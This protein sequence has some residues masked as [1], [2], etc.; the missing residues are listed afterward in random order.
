MD[1]TTTAVDRITPELVMELLRP[2]EVAL[3]ADG[4]RVAFGV[5][6]SFRERGKLIETR[7]WTG[8]V[9]GELRP[10]EAGTLPRFSPD[11]SRLA[12]ASDRGTRGAG[13]SGSTTASSARSGAPAKTSGRPTWI[14]DA[15]GSSAEFWERAGAV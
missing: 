15:P 10:G 14:P 7:L 12:F 11:G 6:A 3:S 5:S 2:S 1:A 8:D 9:D 13:R 4:L